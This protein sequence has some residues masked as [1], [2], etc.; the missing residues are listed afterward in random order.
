VRHVGSLVGFSG[1]LRMLP[2]VGEPIR[3]QRAPATRAEC[4][5]DDS[6]VY[7][8]SG[9]AALALIL[10][11]LSRRALYS[12]LSA[13][14]V[15]IPA[16]CCPDIVSAIAFVG[17][18]AKLVDLDAESPFPSSQ[19]WRAAIDSNTIALIT[20]G[21]LGLRDPFTPQQAFA[22]GLP[23]GAFIEDCCQVHPMAT[24]GATD[25]NIALSFGRGKPVSVMYGGAAL[26]APEIAA[27]CPHL[28]AADRGFGQLA[29]VGITGSL[30]NILRS[31]WLYRWITLLPGMGLGQTRLSSLDGVERMNTRVQACLDVTQGWNDSRRE[32]TQRQLR[33]YLAESSPSVLACD[34][35]RAFGQDSD[36]LLR[37][38]LLLRSRALRDLA[39]ARLNDVGLGASPMY[40]RTLTEIPGVSSLVSHP[41]R[42]IG[43]ATFAD[44]L[45]TLPLHTDVLQR[46]VELMCDILQRVG[47]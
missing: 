5:S 8:Q 34:L 10:H 45:L 44:R 21:F 36:W 33:E 6:H 37:Y 27:W 12:G 22:A 2:P 29:R 28:V 42:N 19:A 13:S 23:A 14:E 9:T 15:L 35:W 40:G 47:A 24:H 18:R 43:A 16:Y 7:L 39:L 25:R 1:R 20:V 30:Y 11:A 32:R 3:L 41:G 31:P 17:L 46:D 38:P 26:L 4:R